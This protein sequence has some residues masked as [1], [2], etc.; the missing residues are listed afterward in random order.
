MRAPSVPTERRGHLRVAF[1]PHARPRLKLPDSA[2]DVIDAAPGGLRLR[3]TDP[4]RPVP[5]ELV[6]GEV[7]E[8]RTG[9]VHLVSGQ[10]SW[11]AS[12]AIGVVLDRM[13]LPVNF[14][15]RELAWVRDQTESRAK[16]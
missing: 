16:A 8:V 7:H 2:H 10:V 9:E 1:M 13:P 15:M 6:D 4:V 3:H 14:V 5:G 11:V 12:T